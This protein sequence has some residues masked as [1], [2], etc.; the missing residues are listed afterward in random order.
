MVFAKVTNEVTKELRN[1]PTSVDDVIVFTKNPF[2]HVIFTRG[3]FHRLRKHNLKLTTAKSQLGAIEENSLG[4][5]ISPSGI[6]LK[7]SKGVAR[8]DMPTPKDMTQLFSISSGFSYER[9]VLSTLA[10]QVQPLNLFLEKSARF[11][12]TPKWKTLGAHS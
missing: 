12:F 8:A 10:K 6:G 11:E 5:S 4:H 9:K 7:A 1:V 2:S 3:L